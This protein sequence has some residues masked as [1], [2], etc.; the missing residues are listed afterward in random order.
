MGSN[1]HKVTLK[2][3]IPVVLIL[4]ATSVVWCQEQENVR[5]ALQERVAELKAL[6]TPN[7]ANQL[8]T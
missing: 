4:A 7:Q 2:I 6:V 5:A 8:A 3:G 1:L